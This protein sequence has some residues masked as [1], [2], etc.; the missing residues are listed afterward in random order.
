MAFREDEA[1]VARIGRVRRIEAHSV[2]KYRRH[3]IGSRQ[4]RSRVAR[5]GFRGRTQRMDA[6]LARGD[7]QGGK[8]LD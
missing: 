8:V 5:A 3:Q 7:L 4:T 2:K 6:Q 1:I